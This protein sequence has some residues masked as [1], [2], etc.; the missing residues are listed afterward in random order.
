MGGSLARKTVTGGIKNR[1]GKTGSVKSR[2]GHKDDVK[3][4]GSG[5]ENVESVVIIEEV[6]DTAEEEMLRKFAIK[7]LDLRS[8]IN[9]KDEKR[10]NDSLSDSETE[11]LKKKIK[12]LKKKRERVKDG[13]VKKKGKKKDKDRDKKRSWSRSLEKALNDLPTENL[14]D[15]TRKAVME[16]TKSGQDLPS[17]SDYSDLDS[18]AGSPGPQV[19]SVISRTD[20][21]GSLRCDILEQTKRSAKKRLGRKRGRET[22]MGEEEK[23]AIER[24]RGREAKIE[25]E[26]KSAIERKSEEVVVVKDEDELRRKVRKANATPNQTYFAKILGDLKKQGQ[27]EGGLRRGDERKKGLENSPNENKDSEVVYDNMRREASNPVKGRLGTKR[28]GEDV[29]DGSE[30][31]KER[32]VK[33]KRGRETKMGEEEK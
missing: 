28:D 5:D 1:L 31:E 22:K 18:P 32:R 3:S 25:E 16:T 27:R 6:E 14:L 24:K 8:R 21:A 11:I 26:E 19:A 23:C 9:T 2:L 17:A 12:K 15:L 33:R 13:K 29:D 10:L 30:E 20:K 4:Q 7:S